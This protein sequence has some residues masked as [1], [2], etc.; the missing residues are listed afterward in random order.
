MNRLTSNCMQI[1]VFMRYSW[2]TISCFSFAMAM[3]VHRIHASNPCMNL[4]KRV[5]ANMRYPKSSTPSPTVV[6]HPENS[7]YLSLVAIRTSS[8]HQIPSSILSSEDPPRIFRRPSAH[9]PKTFRRNGSVE[10]PLE[11]QT[12]HSS[13]F[14]HLTDYIIPML[15]PQ[16]SYP[17]QDKSGS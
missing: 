14:F 10:P 15:L 16:H 6:N 13:S 9:L 17:R 7:L 3:F 4:P 12:F 1:P 2:Y 5:N 8:C 11:V